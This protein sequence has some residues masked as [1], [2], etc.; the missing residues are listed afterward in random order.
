MPE[1]GYLPRDFLY[2][3]KP[4]CTVCGARFQ[5]G[6]EVVYDGQGVWRQGRV[7]G[8]IGALSHR[9]CRKKGGQKA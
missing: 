1:V 4:L 9:K 8:L 6:E 5:D 2:R 3:P 7:R